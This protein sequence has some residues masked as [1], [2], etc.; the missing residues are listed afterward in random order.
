MDVEFAALLKNQTWKLV[1]ARQEQNI[2]DCKWVFKIKQRSDGTLDR[3]KA[4]LVAKGFKQRYGIDYASTFS[5]VIKPTT[6]FLTMSLA[7]SRGWNL[8]Q[9][10]V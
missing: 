6:M 7:V 4:R 3:Y 2:V 9:I 10:D 8:Q 1:P 5:L